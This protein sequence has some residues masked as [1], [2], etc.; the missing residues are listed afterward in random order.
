[1]PAREEVGPT[2]RVAFAPHPEVAANDRDPV[3]AP[4]RGRAANGYD[5]PGPA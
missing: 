5:S 3:R 2:V 1:M 4:V